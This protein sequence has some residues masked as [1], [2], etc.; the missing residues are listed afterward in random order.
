[1][2]TCW[3]NKEDN[4]VFKNLQAEALFKQELKWTDNQIKLFYTK[5]MANNHART[6]DT[7]VS[8]QTFTI[9]GK[10][11]I[12]EIAYQKLFNELDYI[13]SYLNFKDITKEI[14]KNKQSYIL[15]NYDSV[16]KTDSFESVFFFVEKNRIIR[17]N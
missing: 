11:C 5:F 3:F 17:D 6:L 16:A 2:A 12:Y 8:R 13:G 10:E 1:M 15:A 9:N 4:I 14:E 7:A